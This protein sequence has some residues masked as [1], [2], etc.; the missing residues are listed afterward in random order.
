MPPILCGVML[1]EEKR[2]K[3][4]MKEAEKERE[5][6]REMR[7]FAK[8]RRGEGLDVFFILFHIIKITKQSPIIYCYKI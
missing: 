4:R 2:M 8:P 1:C 6:E 7:E 3:L 5:T